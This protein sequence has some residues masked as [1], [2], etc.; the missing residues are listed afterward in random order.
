[1]TESLLLLFFINAGAVARPSA[2]YGQGTGPILLSSVSCNS[3]ASS[4]LK[5]SFSVPSS[6]C[7][8]GDDAGVLCA[9]KLV[10]VAA[11]D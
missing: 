3:Y 2:F 4:L 8:H 11:S 9:G 7:N 1:M 5:C 10:W 6:Y